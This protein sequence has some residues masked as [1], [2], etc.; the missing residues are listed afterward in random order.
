MPESEAG[1]DRRVL[2]TVQNAE[3]PQTAQPQSKRGS[4]A[5]VSLVVIR[6]PRLKQCATKSYFVRLKVA[7]DVSAHSMRS[8]VSL[9]FGISTE[10]E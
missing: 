4:T 5:S 10:T 7:S 8:E 1:G 2:E 9:S 3:L 6:Y